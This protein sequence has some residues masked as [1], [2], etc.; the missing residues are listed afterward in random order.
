MKVQKICLRQYFLIKFSIFFP[1]NGLN[2]SPRRRGPFGAPRVCNHFLKFSE[3]NSNIIL[4]KP[5]KYRQV[6]KKYMMVAYKKKH[7]LSITI[8]FK[9]CKSPEVIL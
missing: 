4:Y 6:C 1:D 8:Q 2:S 9:Y 7:F 5:T 3:K